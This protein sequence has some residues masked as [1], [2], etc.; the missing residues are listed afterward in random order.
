VNVE[1]ASAQCA[2]LVV[3][4]ETIQKAAVMDFSKYKK[5]FQEI[6]LNHIEKELGAVEWVRLRSMASNNRRW[7]PGMGATLNTSATPTELVD[8]WTVEDSASIYAVADPERDPTEIGEIDDLPIY[9]IE[10]KGIYIF[11]EQLH[12]RPTLSFWVTHP[13]WPPGW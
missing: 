4:N 6:V 1:V 3:S 8:A 5:Q 11:G 12:S 2:H 10:G 7:M 13:A 9:Y